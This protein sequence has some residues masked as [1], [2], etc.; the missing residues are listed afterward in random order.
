MFAPSLLVH[1]HKIKQRVFW[2]WCQSK[3]SHG[4]QTCMLRKKGSHL[5]SPRK[6]K[7]PLPSPKLRHMRSCHFPTSVTLLFF[8]FWTPSSLSSSSANHQSSMKITTLVY[9]VAAI[10]D[11][12]STTSACLSDSGCPCTQSCD[13]YNM[14]C[15]PG[16]NN[17]CIVTRRPG[18]GSGGSG[19]GDSGSGSDS[20]SG[21]GSG[22]PSSSAGHKVKPFWFL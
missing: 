15:I 11:L 2:D 19:S 1:R 12:A 13:A 8:F 16:I 5:S 6:R 7:I 20:D 3:Q 21:S 9:P 17:W 10:V 4:K 18:S 22:S 14:V